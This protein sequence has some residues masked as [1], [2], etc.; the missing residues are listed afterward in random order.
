[1]KPVALYRSKAVTCA[2]LKHLEIGNVRKLGYKKLDTRP[3]DE[4]N[5]YA[6]WQLLA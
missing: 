3:D 4:V 5:V 2:G 1:M 6:D